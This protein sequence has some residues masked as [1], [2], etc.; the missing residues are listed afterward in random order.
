M[1]GLRSWT[2]SRGIW[3]RRGICWWSL[4]E[5]GDGSGVFG[6][7]IQSAKA[8]TVACAGGWRSTT[9][10]VGVFFSKANA[11]HSAAVSLA[12]RVSVNF[13]TL[14]LT[15]LGDMCYFFNR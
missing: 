4:S 7:I 3:W 11:R 13:L 10:L 6:G 2:F 12:A 15:G 8:R 9:K 14:G 5:V 1:G